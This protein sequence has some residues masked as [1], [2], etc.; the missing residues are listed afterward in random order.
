MSM[1][2]ELEGYDGVELAELVR[3]KEVKPEEVI[4]ATLAPSPACPIS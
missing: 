4:E 2:S 1:R 3:R